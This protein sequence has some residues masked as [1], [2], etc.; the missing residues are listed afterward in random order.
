MH[1]HVYIFLFANGHTHT[2]THSGTYG[3]AQASPTATTEAADNRPAI[4]YGTG[5]CIVFE[6]EFTQSRV[7]VCGCVCVPAPV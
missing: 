4:P 7:C 5:Y 1:A 2:H 3:A 6:R